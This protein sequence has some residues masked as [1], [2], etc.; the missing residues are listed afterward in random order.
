MYSICMTIENIKKS[1]TDKL[2]FA[3][4]IGATIKLDFGD[5]GLLF[6]DGTQNPAVVS[7]EDGDAK[8]TFVCSPD[9]LQSIMD[10]TQD[11]TMA[12]MTGKL[13]VQGSMGYALKL[14]ALLED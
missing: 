6:I 13:K 12:F 1:I 9:L 5:D 3:P 7:E 8:T 4:Q 11:P 10:G 14:S 2:A